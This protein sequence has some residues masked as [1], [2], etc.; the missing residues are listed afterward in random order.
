[1]G[2]WTVDALPGVVLGAGARDGG[3]TERVRE[4]RDAR[5]TLS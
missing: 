2:R 1:M 3:L 4:R 5:E